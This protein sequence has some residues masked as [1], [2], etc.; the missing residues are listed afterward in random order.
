MHAIT[1]NIYFCDVIS[2]KSMAEGF[3]RV[4]VLQYHIFKS[5][6]KFR[7]GNLIYFERNGPILLHVYCS[8]PPI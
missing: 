7:I 3:E 2:I 1:P 4:H 8:E 6:L 5:L